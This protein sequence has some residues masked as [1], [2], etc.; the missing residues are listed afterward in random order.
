MIV[1]QQ[2]HPLEQPDEI[3]PRLKDDAMGA[4]L[5]MFGSIAVG[6]PLPIINLMASI[7]YYYAYRH[8]SRFVKFHALQSLYSQLPTSILNG[9]FMFW[10]FRVIISGGFFEDNY[11]PITAGF[12]NIGDLYWAF[13]YTLI[14]L[15][16][17][18][19][20]FSI[21]AATRARKGKMYYMFFFG[22]LAYHQAYKVKTGK[23]ELDPSLPVEQN[24]PPI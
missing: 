18:Y 11:S 17:L 8:K 24:K 20:I 7:I 5:M 6:L 21:V 15:N 22:K 16:L 3:S 14:L 19:F 12:A 10:T 4:Y 13:L 2:Y 9:V 1:D 23:D